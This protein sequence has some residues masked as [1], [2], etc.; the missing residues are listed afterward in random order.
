V[1]QSSPTVRALFA[2]PDY[3][4]LW[5]I[6]ALVGVVRWLE[7][8]ALGVFA[9]QVTQSPTY[10]ALIALVRMAPWIVLGFLIGALADYFDK[11]RMLAAGFLVSG[12]AFA[13]MAVLS[14]FGLA[15]YGTAICAA[16]VSGLL[17]TTDLP[18]RRRLLVEA[19]GVH[20]M[21]AAL[22][23][24]NSSYFAARAI[25][26][27]LGGVAYQLL[28]IEGIFAL[29][30]AV[31]LAC[32]YL[33]VGLTGV[34]PSPTDRAHVGN[35]RPSVLSLL[36]P[37]RELILSRRFQVVVGVTIVFNVWCFPFLSMVPVIGEKEFGLTPAQIGAL[38]ACEGVGGTIGA[39]LIGLLAGQRPYFPFYYF[40]VMGFLA[41]MLGVSVSLTLGTT[42]VGLLL[43]G[44]SA[45]GFSAVQYALIYT[46]APPDMR[47]RAAGFLSIF[48]GTST[49]GFYNTGWVFSRFETADAMMIIALEGFIPL[50]ILGLL[51]MRAKS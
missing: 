10:V 21:T 44:A 18:V 17:W 25:G 24:D 49:L 31:Y 38:S 32:F 9:Y 51:W 43:I 16:L 4:R 15:G 33:S 29:S 26:P 12:V 45:S 40:G 35:P 8:L 50:L 5:T 36:I 34:E 47:G 11:Q 41:L 48:I 14:A 2:V 6:G 19:A 28:G 42:I 13:A 37:P 22:G 23:F 20:R 30:A 7:F 1:L 27:I 46:M 39:I 3:R